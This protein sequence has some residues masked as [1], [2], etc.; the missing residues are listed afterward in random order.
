MRAHADLLAPDPV[1]V[2][3]S[4]AR[5]FRRGSSGAGPELLRDDELVRYRARTAALAPPELLSWLH[6][7]D[8]RGDHRDG[9]RDDH[10]DHHRRDLD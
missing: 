1:G 2:M 4:R 10:H 8:D 7:D 5:F 6:R 3:K 9:H